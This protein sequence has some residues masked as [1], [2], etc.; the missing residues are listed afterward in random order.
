ML[1]NYR[2]PL[3][4]FEGMG[5][6]MENAVNNILRIRDLAR[7]EDAVARIATGSLVAIA[8][9]NDE[10]TVGF[11]QHTL[12]SLDAGKCTIVIINQDNTV[13]FKS[14][15]GSSSTLTVATDKEL[16]DGAFAQRYQNTITSS[17]TNCIRYIKVQ[18]SAGCDS[19]AR[20][21]EA[22]A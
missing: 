20:Q 3:K 17:D 5:R 13:V 21:A 22:C 4:H 8:M 7:F 18:P 12:T 16:I 19:V 6:V 14:S 2:G 9:H 1:D 11:K 10:S 15:S